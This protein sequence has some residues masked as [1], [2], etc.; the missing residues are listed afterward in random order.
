MAKEQ[1]QKERKVVHGQFVENPQCCMC[2]AKI[3]HEWLA[4]DYT[5]LI[6]ASQECWNKWEN[7]RVEDQ[8]KYRLDKAIAE[9]LA[10][11]NAGKKIKN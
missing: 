5:M 2:G 7:Q 10:V 1:V 9:T 6:C 11:F 4:G 8:T 3:E